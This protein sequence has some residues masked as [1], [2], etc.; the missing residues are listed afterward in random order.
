MVLNHYNICSASE[1]EHEYLYYCNNRTS[2][3]MN[4]PIGIQLNSVRMGSGRVKWITMENNEI[5]F[6]KQFHQ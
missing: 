1:H 4:I 3:H 5:R 6:A 2:C